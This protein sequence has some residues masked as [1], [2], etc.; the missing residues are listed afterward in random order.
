M[1]SSLPL[2][3]AVEH[4]AHHDDDRQEYLLRIG[5]IGADYPLT[6]DIESQSFGPA[7]VANIESHAGI[8]LTQDLE[9][10]FIL[11][12]FDL[13]SPSLEDTDIGHLPI[14]NATDWINASFPLNEAKLILAE[15]KK[16]VKLDLD[17][18]PMRASAFMPMGA[19]ERRGW[20]YV[21]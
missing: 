4:V 21:R 6:A 15:L 12:C 1:H 19:P 10:A 18:D 7:R 3:L 16:Q 9:E 20:H 8:D 5:V 17:F 11:K 14:A 13:V 2:L